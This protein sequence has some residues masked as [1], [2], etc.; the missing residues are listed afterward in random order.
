MRQ[1]FFFHFNEIYNYATITIV[2]VEKTNI[3]S[4]TVGHSRILLITFKQYFG[5]FCFEP[6]VNF[7][8]ETSAGR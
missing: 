8:A 6:A 1:T 3:E 5:S 2:V 4:L 7:S